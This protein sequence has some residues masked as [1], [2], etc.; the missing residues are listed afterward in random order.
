VEI[1]SSSND[2]FAAAA[3]RIVGSM[4]FSPAKA[5]GR[6]VRVTTTLPVTWTIGR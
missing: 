2:E 5:G 4:R 1:V 6:T 3:R